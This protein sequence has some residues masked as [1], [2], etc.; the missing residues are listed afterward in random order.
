MVKSGVYTESGILITR[1]A[2]ILGTSTG[3]TFIQGAAKPATVS[4]RVLTIEAGASSESA[5][6]TG[7]RNSDSATGLIES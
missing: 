1:S 6:R 3:R 4:D 7:F 2:T 5:K